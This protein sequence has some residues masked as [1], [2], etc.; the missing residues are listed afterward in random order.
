MCSG[1]SDSVRISGCVCRGVAV[2]VCVG[3]G[4]SGCN[5]C[6]GKCV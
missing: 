4:D 5:M 3:L 2:C 1:V 6:L